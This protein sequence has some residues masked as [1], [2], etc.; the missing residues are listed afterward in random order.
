MAKYT[1][2]MQRSA[3]SNSLS[4]GAIQAP[5]SGMRRIKLYGLVVGSEDTPANLANL[6]QLQRSTTAG[7][8]TN[9]RTPQP[10][11]L[12]DAAAVSVGQDTATVDPTLTSNAFLGDIP[13][14]LQASWNWQCIPG[15]EIVVPA[16]AN[17]GLALR[18]PTVGSTPKGTAIFSFEEQ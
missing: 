1:L 6:W 3:L 15:G 9:A 12:A 17:N 10:L 11:D 8:W 4:F 16:T 7:T 5:G 2:H 13:L 18:T 14:N